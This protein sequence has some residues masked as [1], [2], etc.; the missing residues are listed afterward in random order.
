M[1]IIADQNIPFVCEAFSTFGDVVTVSG[2]DIHPETV[3]DA[4]ILLVRSIT[5]VD[6]ELLKNS[7]VRFVGTAT[8]GTDHVDTE[9]LKLSSIGF[10]GAPGSNADSVADYITAALVEIS[11]VRGVELSGSSLGIIGAGNVGSRVARRAAALG[12]RCLVNDP[13][14]QRVCDDGSFLKLEEVLSCADFVTIHVPLTVAGPDATFKMADRK[15]IDKIKNGAILINTSRGEVID[16]PS[17]IALRNR[18]GG[19]VADVWY[20]E[21][22]INTDMLKIADIATPH[23]AGYSFEGKLNGVEAVYNAACDFFSH[24]KLWNKNSHLTDACRPVIDVSAS[25]NPIR[26][27]LNRAYD[28][29]ADDR[30][31]KLV[32]GMPYM[33]RAGYFDLLRQQYQH[34]REFSHFKVRCGSGQEKELKILSALGFHH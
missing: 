25:N 15:F 27:C 13:P 9:Y 18:L 21:P 23:I 14:L 28:I 10:A 4:S 7:N 16:E 22:N 17:L 33:E 24:E 8:I 20:G 19:F 34:R 32:T 11:R 3:K 12:M 5:R 26:F 2:R 1:L 30:K 31:L 29:M 6:S